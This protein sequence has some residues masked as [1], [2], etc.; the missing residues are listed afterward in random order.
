MTKCDKKIVHLLSEKNG[1]SDPMS[2]RL[3]KSFEK[4]APNITFDVI[5]FFFIC[6]RKVRE[7]RNIHQGN[8]ITAKTLVKHSQ[9]NVT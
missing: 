9:A 4:H 1:K 8:R 7:N 6:S 5:Y 2:Y 3:E